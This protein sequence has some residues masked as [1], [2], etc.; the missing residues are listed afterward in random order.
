METR[1]IDLFELTAETRRS[2]DR[3]TPWLRIYMDEHLDRIFGAM[4]RA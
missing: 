3:F 2:P 1:W 4:V